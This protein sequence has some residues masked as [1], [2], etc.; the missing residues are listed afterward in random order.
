MSKFLH[1]LWHGFLEQVYLI[2]LVSECCFNCN[3]WHVASEVKFYHKCAEGPVRVLFIRHDNPSTYWGL[4]LD[5]LLLWGRT[6]DLIVWW[7]D[8]HD[9]VILCILK[10]E[11]V[12]QEFSAGNNEDLSGSIVHVI[13]SDSNFAHEINVICIGVPLLP[14]LVIINAPPNINGWVVNMTWCPHC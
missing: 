1:E 8:Y 2:S 11:E 13:S 10:G 14:P 7:N 5:N 12:H 3:F 6:F 4:S 9:I